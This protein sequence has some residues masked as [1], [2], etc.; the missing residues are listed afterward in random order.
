MNAY[1]PEWRK[2]D[3]EALEIIKERVLR[4]ERL[5]ILDGRHRPDHKLHGVYTGLNAKAE[6]LEN[7]MAA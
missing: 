6:E 3:E 4:M 2:E 1:K 5:Y 7:Y